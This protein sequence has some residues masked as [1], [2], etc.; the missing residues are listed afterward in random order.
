M[1]LFG[2]I[3]EIITGSKEA[4][5]PSS[6]DAQVIRPIQED[7]ALE[8]LRANM[9]PDGTMKTNAQKLE[10]I[11]SAATTVDARFEIARDAYM[12]YLNAPDRRKVTTD[13]T[14]THEVNESIIINNND[15]IEPYKEEQEVT[16]DLTELAKKFETAG[17][18]QVIAEYVTKSSSS[19]CNGNTNVVKGRKPVQEEI[20]YSLLPQE[21]FYKN[22]EELDAEAT[23]IGRKPGSYNYKSVRER[24]SNTEGQPIAERNLVKD[25]GDLDLLGKSAG[26]WNEKRPSVGI[27]MDS[28]DDSTSLIP[29]FRTSA[30]LMS[31]QSQGF[32]AMV[33][34]YLEKPLDPGQ[35]ETDLLIKLEALMDA[36]T[37]TEENINQLRI[38]MTLRNPN[39]RINI[40]NNVKPDGT[41]ETS[42]GIYSM[43]N[44]R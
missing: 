34:L 8:V 28:K 17:A 24:W 1:G 35:I 20:G 36:A 25:G 39:H 21:G 37:L 22:D 15:V 11:S 13:Q 4:P 5:K 19:E 10:A 27:H 9:N 32:T 18:N 29:G 12:E 38:I 44:D 31:G 7:P 33:N 14:A 26:H 43:G 42:F 30:K 3:G 40:V 41:R 2:T 23:E 16:G 6:N